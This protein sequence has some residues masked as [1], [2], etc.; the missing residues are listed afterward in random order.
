MRRLQIV[1]IFIVSGCVMCPA[2]GQSDVIK[3]GEERFSFVLGTFLPAFKSEVKID[4]PTLGSGSNVNL[5]DDLGVERHD[6]AIWTGAEWRFAPNHRIGINYSRFKL[7]GTRT[8]TRQIQIGDEIYPAGATLSSEFK[9]QVIPITYSYSLIKRES[10]E[11]AAT[12]G[13]HWS[14]LS[15]KSHGSASLSGLDAGTDVSAKADAPLPLIGLRYDHHFSPRWSA[16]VQGAFFSMRY[17]K[18]TTNVEGDVWSAR[19]EAEY[20]FSRH[21]GVG[22]AIDSFRI[23]VEASSGSWQG[24]FNYQYWGPQLYL[25]ARF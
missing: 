7:T 12:I 19:V 11:L 14:R 5:R 24:G 8:A 1:S 2:F 17:G 16:G 23:D 22:A 13:I 21:W 15:F 4:N 10:D 6:T 9:V 3:P 20:R 18:D 25:K